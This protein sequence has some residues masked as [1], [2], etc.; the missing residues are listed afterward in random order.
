MALPTVIIEIPAEHKITNKINLV[1]L[2]K[3]KEI[4]NLV[5]ANNG[6][7]LDLIKYS[8]LFTFNSSVLDNNSLIGFLNVLTTPITQN[9]KKAK[10]KDPIA[11]IKPIAE[12]VCSPIGINQKLFNIPKNIP[13]AK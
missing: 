5:K 12:K 4:L 13:W 3:D 11:P 7:F 6:I 1:N 8:N 2:D 10:Y 9:N